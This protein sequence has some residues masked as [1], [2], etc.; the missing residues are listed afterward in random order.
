MKSSGILSFQDESPFF[1][2]VPP[3]SMG[4]GGDSYLV[5]GA[6]TLEL[7][8]PAGSLLAFLGQVDLNN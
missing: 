6:K 5:P 1:P 2:A 4:A 3:G 7:G 8:W